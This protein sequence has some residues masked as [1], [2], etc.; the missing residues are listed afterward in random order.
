MDYENENVGYIV[1][2]LSTCLLKNS[3]WPLYLHSVTVHHK[4]YAQVYKTTV[5]DT[6]YKIC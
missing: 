4:V 2:C 6:H 5:Y 1:Y 3:F